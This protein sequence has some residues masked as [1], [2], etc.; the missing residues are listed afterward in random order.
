VAKH[1]AS[2]EVEDL[3]IFEIGKV[4]Y[5]S[6][7]LA[8]ERIHLGLL[9]KGEKSLLPWEGYR[10]PYDLFDLK[11]ILEELSFVLKLTLEIRPHSQEPFLKK[12]VS[13]DI[14]AEGEKIGFAGEV[15]KLILDELDLRGPLFVSELDLSKVIEILE[16]TVIPFKIKKPPKYPATFRDVSCIVRKEVP[17]GEIL[18]FV[19]SLKI[20]Y[21]EKVELIALYEGPPIP[22]EEKSITLRFWYRSEE[23][24]LQDEEVNSLQEEVAKKIF[25]RFKAR[26]R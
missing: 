16:K 19:Y 1:N 6:D 7:E 18:S 22:E 10:R 17:A 4:F 25:E 2:R 8:E 13:Y 15:K 14:Y 24:T 26:P 12:G 23:R 20:P 5:P 21:L 9:L 11:G 3:A